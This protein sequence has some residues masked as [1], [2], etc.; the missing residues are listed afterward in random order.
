[1]LFNMSE[2]FCWFGDTYLKMPLFSEKFETS[3]GKE[4]LFHNK[5]VI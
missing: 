3:F 1:M 4:K 2:D 5:E